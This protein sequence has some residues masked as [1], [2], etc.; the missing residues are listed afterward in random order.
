MYNYVFWSVRVEPNFCALSR[1]DNVEN[2]L[3]LQKGIFIGIFPENATFFMDKNFPKAIKL[4]DNVYNLRGLIVV[5]KKLKEFIEKTEPPNVEYLPVSIINHKGRIASK[6]YFIINPFVPQ[7]CIDLQNS[8]IQWNAIDPE[9]ISACFEMVIDE[10]RID[11]SITIFRLKY[12]PTKILVKRDMA[13]KI[14]N[15]GFIGTRFIEI[16]DLEY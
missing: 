2:S 8:D 3:D 11:P 16:E 14:L 10:T 4:A 13:N 12:Y 6:D 7:D 1:L 15:G 5:S 9:I